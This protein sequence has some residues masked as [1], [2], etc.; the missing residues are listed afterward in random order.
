[1]LQGQRQ[2]FVGLLTMQRSCIVLG[3]TKSKIQ[4][5]HQQLWTLAIGA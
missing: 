4:E 2:V 3:V 5:Q 1:M